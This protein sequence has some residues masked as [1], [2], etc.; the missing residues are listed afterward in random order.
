MQF[1]R[2]DKNRKA[3]SFLTA[4]FMLASTMFTPLV[5]ASQF[6]RIPL[7]SNGVTPGTG[8]L[9]VSPSAISFADQY[10]NTQ[11]ATQTVT[12]SNTGA[13]DVGLSAPAVS[14]PFAVSTTCPD[15]LGASA[16]CTYQV[17]FTPTQMGSAAG[18]LVIPTTAGSQS[19]NLSGLGL[20]TSDAASIDSLT[21][22]QPVNTTSAPKTVTLTNTGNT[23]LKVTG[24]AVSGATFVVTHNCPATLDVGASCS[25]NVTFSPTTMGGASGSLAFNT[26][27][28]QQLVVLAGTGLLAVPQLSPQTIDFGDQA[29]NSVSPVKVVTLSNE[30]NT[31]L[32]ISPLSTQAPFALQSTTCTTSLGAGQSCQASITFAPTAMGGAGDVLHVPLSTGA[33]TVTLTGNG[34]LTAG[35]VNN[36]ALDF[37][38][39]KVG[40]TSVTQGVTLEN[41][42]N[43]PLQV[44]GVMGTGPFSVAHN[45]PAAVS[46]GGSCQVN[47]SFNPT[48]MGPATGAVRLATNG[49]TYT[50]N[51]AGN[52]LLA[53]PQL[54]PASFTFPTQVVGTTSATQVATLTNVGNTPMAL[55]TAQMTGPFSQT[56]TCGQ[57]LAAGAS[58]AYSV[59]FTPVAMNA[60]S[61]TLV[62]PTDAGTQTVNLSGY[63]QQTSGALS[64][65]A[66]SFGNQ[67]VGTTSVAQ[68]AQLTNTGNTPLS[69]KS[70]AATGQFAASSD[71]AA[72]V[73]PGAGC[74]VSVVFSPSTIGSQT[75]TLTVTTDGGTYTA[76][77]TGTG[78]LAITGVNPTSLSFGNQT[79]GTTSAAQSVTLSNTGNTST[80]VAAATATGPF[81]VTTNCAATLAAGASCSYNV[82]FTPGAM[83]AATG[84][85]TV[86]TGVGN[87]TVGL[88]GF[89]QQT[90]GALD[91]NSVAFGNQAVNTTSVTQSVTLTNTGNLPLGVSGVST[92]GQFQTSH[93][94]PASLAVSS[95]CTVNVQFSPTTI[96]V[97]SGVL[98]VATA[99]GTYTATLGGMGLLAITGVNPTSLS[100]G[101]QAVNTTSAAQTVTLS[102]TG[103]TPSALSAATL[104][105]PFAMTTTCGA[106]LAAGANCSYSVTF[107]PPAMN[108][109]SGTLSIPTDVGT[110]AVALTGYGQ[111]T[112]GS[113]STNTLAFGS[114]AVSTT[115]SAQSVTLNNTGNL[116][117]GVTSVAVTG[118][119]AVSN[120]CGSSVAVGTSC[121]ISVTFTPTAMGAQSGTLSAVTASGTYTAALS[122]TGLL[123]VVAAN[124]GSLSFGNVVVNTTSGAQSVSLT[125]TGNTVSTVSA[126]S[127]TGPFAFTTTCGASLA[128]STSCAYSVTFTPTTMN[129]ASGTL[130]IPTA[131][132]TKTV[133]LSGNGQQTSG[134]LNLG[135]LA[136]GNLPVGA[137]S[138]AQSVIL[139]NTGNTPLTV[140]SVATSGQ[141]NA[142]HNCPASLAA[143]NSCTV[144]TTFTPTSIGAQAGTLSVVTGG[145]T[146][147]VNLSGTG[148]LAVATVSPTSLA[149]SNQTVNTTSAA[150]TV[151]LS[152]T[153]N[154]P[155]ALSAATVTGPFAF[156][157]TCGAT[158]AASASCS[159]S[160]TFTPTAMNAASGTLSIPTDVG[161]KTVSL[162]G[163]GL[164]TSGTLTPASVAFGSLAVGATSSTQSVTLTNTGNTALG[165]TSVSV[166][167]QYAQTNTCGSS[168][169]AGTN[170]VVS[171]SFKP[172][173]MGAQ[174][175]T[176]TVVT[177]AGTYTSTLSGTGL[178]AVVGAS[179]ASVAFGNQT[180]NITSA[181]QTITLSNTGNTAT[182]VST[183]TLTG[184]FAFTTTCGTSIGASASCTYSVT[185]TPTA[186][187]GASGTLSIPTGTGTQTVSLS[188]TGLQTSGSVDKDSLA[189]GNQ[190]VST[191]SAAQ[192]VTLT[193][194]GNTALG[195]SGVS[196]SAQYT[197]SNNCGSSVAS[198]SSCTINVSFAPTAMGSQPGTLTVTTGAGTYT[199]TLSGTGLLAVVGAN[200]ST[201][202]FGNQTVS[203][204]SAAQN[205]TLS[206]TGNTAATVSAATATGPFAVTTTCGT[207]LAA[208]A[209]CTYSVT[210]TPTAMNGASGTL[211]MPTS[212]GTKT[213]TLTGTGQQTSGSLT[214][215][216]LAFGNVAVSSTSSAQS[217][218]V[219]NTGNTALNITGVAASGQFSATHNCPASLAAGATCTAN[220]TFAPTSMGAQSGNLTVTTNGGTY[221]SSLSGTG[222]LA[223]VGTSPASLTFTAQT[224]GTTSAAQVVTLSNTGNTST[225][226]S[227]ASITGPFAVT[228]TCSTTI[229]ASAS[230]TYSVT[231][232][233]T[234][235][236]GA[237]G[238]LSIPTGTGTKTVSLTGT[239]QQ[240]VLS[241]TPS[242]LAFGNVQAGQSAATAFTLKN[243]GNIAAASVTVTPPA[244][245][246][247][248]NN[249]G[250]SL[251][252][253]ASCTVTVTFAPGAVQA[254]NGTIAVSAGGQ[255]ANVSVTG[256]GTAQSLSNL[257]GS[258]INM[259][260][261][262][263]A[264]ASSAWTFTFKNTGYGPVTIADHGMSSGNLG[265]YVG[266]TIGDGTCN[267]GT[268]LQAGQSCVVQLYM[269][270][271]GSYTGTGYLNS[272][273]GQLTFSAYGTAV[274][275]YFSDA[276]LG[277]IRA[278]TSN[279]KW[280]S[281]TN[282]AVDTF[283]NVTLNVGWPYS[284]SQSNCG[285]ALGPGA[286][287]S[288]V[289]TFNPGG[290]VGTWNGAYLNAVGFHYQMTNGVE[291]TGWQPANAT[292][293]AS[294]YGTGTP[295]C[296][297]GAAAWGGNAT[298]YPGSS[299]PNC[300]TFLVLVVGGGG[301]GALS[302]QRIAYGPY[303]GGGGS[304]YVN[305][306][307]ANGISG[308]IAITVGAGAYA[309]ST[310]DTQ[311]GT[312]CFGGICA[313]GGHSGSQ[314]GPGGAG[315][316][317]GGY[318]S[319]NIAG[320]GGNWGGNSSDGYGPGQGNYAGALANFHLNSLTGGGGGQPMSNNTTT[321]GGGGGGGILLNGGGP[322][323]GAG[324][325]SMSF[326]PM[327][328]GGVG[329]GAGGG[330]GQFMCTSQCWGGAGQGAGGLV[331][332][333]WSQ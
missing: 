144:N 252:A 178:L 168:I 202:A 275:P 99:G 97:Q 57:S 61:G 42:G 14:G 105:G 89:G 43:T 192:V 301:A 209:S 32:G 38:D 214:P 246:S 40:T 310:Y 219:S 136:F 65:N 272:S 308:A 234:A 37:G 240:V 309:A 108:A 115:S 176:L 260:S 185:F 165:V 141:F 281:L 314:N 212:A 95:S 330:G 284:I 194:T 73:A 103:N 52:G 256:T 200:P 55:S 283:R 236:N 149:F 70:L 82:T 177:A 245:Y 279:A 313:A 207:S 72:T 25:A 92:T 312:S 59:A 206:N 278:N 218:T 150:Q 154:T 145:G 188:G 222:L 166:S 197:Q 315:G 213:V 274:A 276:N 181:A 227:A 187:N 27:A 221:A 159:Y 253:G 102:N 225:S 151:S 299:A 292:Y 311:G 33:M 271:A 291:Q 203:T 304:G 217:I 193:N 129:G 155:S 147:T 107:T 2:R 190:A 100:F 48:A 295:F 116:A 64:K 247:Q 333:E 142:S 293:N 125:N 34:L 325:Y 109:A 35:A 289:L 75:G 220:V 228:T 329:Y 229:A 118:P 332:V 307:W 110:K 63:G 22:Q 122:G 3:L 257:T 157:T 98:S 286:S 233:P 137:T 81:A 5:E 254:Y 15:T 239:G 302:G 191:T 158:L 83:N 208:S 189:F 87:Q 124:P 199:T 17:S 170:C 265:F 56:T 261:N 106:T 130:T 250:T 46:S 251:A 18:A 143:G 327:G 316:S 146:Y 140:S 320:W 161:T 111:Q 128:A 94:C 4:A 317:G 16:T 6:Y 277:S 76:D 204:T 255:N 294:V 215:A 331:Y 90:T 12:L 262:L 139:N 93:N 7:H 230:C 172:T 31:A 266:G 84:T 91:K 47:V 44:T 226:V 60:A 280:V 88:S 114:Q 270:G 131:T 24:V 288:F 85:L 50:I 117:L 267:S 174:A 66:F 104:T 68:T 53:K 79:V 249:C 30:G 58:C 19:V 80:S 285:S 1:F 326:T 298:F 319:P 184:P 54:S 45:C 241:S 162:S 160:V 132:G 120:T 77:L 112:S 243:A 127:I 296:T 71:C 10:I 23:P 49:G 86:P 224:V 138:A 78:L 244:G 113:L 231:F 183:A 210:F 223:V 101:N 205:V 175:G 305:V 235:M 201:L 179:P 268:V 41:T 51:L 173:T 186:M 126:A 198:G 36:T 123:A 263:P 211:S 195:V 69:V 232:T 306:Q 300:N 11:S 67:P 135:T 328:Q 119:Y 153:G 248:S 169:A 273:A 163:T 321:W 264:D 242:S 21:F 171:V 8:T 322:S 121:S 96:G 237:S 269:S 134:S 148:L 196:A 39:V 238:T 13:T 29:V 156:T 182:S 164:Q 318:G 290:N 62:I 180:L 152:N 323:G 28:G 20:Q 282:P 287:C 133:T 167:G 216:S 259:G 297:P 303:S 74:T 258:N 9:V 26:A 324:A